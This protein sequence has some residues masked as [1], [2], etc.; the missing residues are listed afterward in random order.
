MNKVILSGNL[1]KDPVIRATESGKKIASFSLATTR[2]NKEKTTDWHNIT[3]WEGLAELAE[4][5]LKKGSSVIIVGEIH[6]RS[7]EDKDGVTKNVTDI[8]GNEI[9][10]NGKA[11]AKPQQGDNLEGKFQKK[12]Q[13][14]EGINDLPY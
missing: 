12:R 5:Y 6:Y 1:G 9:H 2:R 3:V 13:E 8:V 11:E 4:K 7:Y 14:I 10:F